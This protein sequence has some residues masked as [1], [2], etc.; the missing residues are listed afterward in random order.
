MPF[1][2]QLNPDDIIQ[3]DTPTYEFDLTIDLARTPSKIWM[4][5]KLAPSWPDGSAVF[6]IIGTVNAV[7]ATTGVDRTW[8]TY[9]HLSATQSAAIPETGAGFDVQVKLDN[10]DVLTPVIGTVKAHP[11]YTATTA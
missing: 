9:F 1:F 6:Q 4:T 5:A 2:V 11:G 8:Q 3:G 10:S 7:I